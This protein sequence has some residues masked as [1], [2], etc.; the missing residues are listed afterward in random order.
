MEDGITSEQGIPTKNITRL[1]VLP[2]DSAAIIFFA[3]FASHYV[4]VFGGGFGFVRME[5]C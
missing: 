5:S 4:T 2:F 3:V 1:I